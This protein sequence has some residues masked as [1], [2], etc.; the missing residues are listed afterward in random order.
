MRTDNA[1]NEVDTTFRDYENAVISSPYAPTPVVMH[2][3]AL[4]MIQFR[5]TT[6]FRTP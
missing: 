2:T 3:P 4:Q 5:I 6:Q 1:G